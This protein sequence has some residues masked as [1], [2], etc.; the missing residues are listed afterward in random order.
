M[1]IFLNDNH[2]FSLAGYC[3][4]NWAG[5]IQSRRSV[6]GLFLLF[7]GSPISWKS[8]NQPTIALSSAEAEYRALRKIIAEVAWLVRLFVDFGVSNL[9]LVQV[10]CDN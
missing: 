4:S 9:T 2:D 6:M 1:G 3:D 8:K 7:G 10:F 5:C